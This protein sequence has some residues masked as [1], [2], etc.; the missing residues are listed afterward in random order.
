MALNESATSS[1]LVETETQQGSTQPDPSSNP[2]ETKQ[3]EQPK[4]DAELAQ[5]VS[6]LLGTGDED[7]TGTGDESSTGTEDGDLNTP[8]PT[9]KPKTMAEA[10]ERLGIEAK[11]LYKLS[12]TTG[13]GDTVSIG[14]L[15]DAHQNRLA[16][17]QET[18][19]REVALDQRETA[20]TADQRIWAEMGDQ[21]AQILTPQVRQQL[22]ERMSERESAERR[23]LLQALP[24]MQD[25]AKFDQFR[26]DVVDT[27]GKYGYKPHEIV[28]GDHRQL[29]VLRDLIRLQH[30]VDQLS[31]F[32]P[33][34]LMPRQSKPQGRGNPTSRAQA[35]L[36]KAKGG[37][38]AHKVD[39]VAQLLKG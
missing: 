37:T 14:D 12:I 20:I 32:Q 25:E 3:T 7:R 19:K 9:G 8:S 34:P 26:S 1:G 28:V 2:S 6:D 15:K 18:A 10:A 5:S 27:L 33:E 24:E 35:A 36:N 21:L 23:K 29:I 16:A 38:E 22:A 30:R 4:T 39:A 11:D 13:D 17:E 31:K